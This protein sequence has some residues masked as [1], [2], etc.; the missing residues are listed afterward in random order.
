MI[1][2]REGFAGTTQCSLLVL[3]Y[4]A[5]SFPKSP[6]DSSLSSVED[7][8]DSC[9]QILVY[10]IIVSALNI[11]LISPS[12]NYD[13]LSIYP[14][15]ILLARTILRYTNLDYSL[16]THGLVILIESLKS[17]FVFIIPKA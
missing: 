3:P 1:V 9:L 16:S 13:D 2:E 7:S 5:L 17:N 8:S 4:V 14:K 12:S 11:L 6:P 15:K 10:F